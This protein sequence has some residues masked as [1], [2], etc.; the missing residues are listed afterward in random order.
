MIKPDW[1]H[2]DVELYCGDCL[3]ILP[4]LE[5]VDCVVTSP[6]YDELRN[7]NKS[8]SWNRRIWEEVIERMYW[9]MCEGGVVVWVVGDATENGSETGTSFNQALCFMDTGFNL[10][11]TMI[12][13]K[14]GQGATGSNSCYWHDFEYMFVFTKGTPKAGVLICDRKNTT[15]PRV[16]IES[17][18]H[19]FQDGQTKG[20]RV[21]KRKAHGKR[22]NIWKYHES[23]TRIDHPA[24]FP[25]KLA[26]DHI[27][28][29][30]DEKETILDP[31]MG[32][33]TTG[34]AAVRLGRKFIGIEREPKYFDIAVKRIK[35]E[36]E[37]TKL[38]L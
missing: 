29:W 34:V 1:K 6:P 8:L 19:R 23:G 26:Q 14:G 30:S 33:G 25:I 32:S 16:S 18:G 5:G 9:T 11:D 21:I 22:F 28:S 35:A 31:F 37:Q 15:K 38:G 10:L 27:I 3:D 24:V 2:G 12:Y 17:Q 36:M 4:G 7:Y 20:Q 13:S